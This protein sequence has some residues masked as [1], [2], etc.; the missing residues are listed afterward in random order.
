MQDSLRNFISKFF[1]ALSHP[2]RIKIFELH[3]AGELSFIDMQD[4]LGIESSIV[5]QHLSVCPN[6]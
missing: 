2:A 1:K 5:S 3:R 4:G 6:A